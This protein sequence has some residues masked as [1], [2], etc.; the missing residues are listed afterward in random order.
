MSETAKGRMLLSH[1]F[2]LYEG[3]LPALNREQFA[4]IFIDGLQSQ[5]YTSCKFIKNPHWIVEI[6]FPI[7]EFKAA[8]IGKICGD[9]L[10][11]K[12]Q[13]QKSNSSNSNGV[14]PDILFLGGKKTTPAISTSATSLQ[15][16][17]WG[18]DV[19][20][21]PAA[22]I[23]LA[24]IQWDATIASKPDDNVFKIEYLGSNN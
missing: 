24:N 20:E 1:N 19:V 23:F 4:Q 5:P 18:V 14:M 3:E 22:E 8:E 11:K 7:A 21:T 9:I 13:E 16:G 6:I 12:R 15:P 17:D 10:L 2:N